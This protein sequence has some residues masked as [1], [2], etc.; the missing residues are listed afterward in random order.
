[1]PAGEES[2]AKAVGRTHFLYSQY[3]NRFYSC[4]LD[5]THLWRALAYVERN[6][7]RARRQQDNHPN[8]PRGRLLSGKPCCLHVK[9]AG[10][11]RQLVGGLL[12][13]FAGRL[14]GAVAG[15]GFDADQ[16]RCRAGLGSLQGG[17]ELEA[18]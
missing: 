11:E 15:S 17:G 3:I 8:L 4:L 10:E 2:L 12:D 1:M 16:D 6:P 18:V 5:E 7:V 14:A 9:R 13:A